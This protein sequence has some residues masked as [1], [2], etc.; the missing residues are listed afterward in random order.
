MGR[1]I[2]HLA[3]NGTDQGPPGGRLKGCG[4]MPQIT[5]LPP[6]KYPVAL[7]LLVLGTIFRPPQVC[8]WGV[9]GPSYPNDLYPTH[10]LP[11]I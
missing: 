4:S 11:K 9:L 6:L 10:F 1:G 2:G 5:P 8:F 7:S 3:Q